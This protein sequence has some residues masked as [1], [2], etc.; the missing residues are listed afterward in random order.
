MTNPIMT[1]VH[2]VLRSQFRI[3]LLLCRI[4]VV[5]SGSNQSVKSYSANIVDSNPTISLG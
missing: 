2:L 3:S 5:S 1:T 4:M